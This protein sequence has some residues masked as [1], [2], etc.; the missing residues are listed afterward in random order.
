MAFID[1]NN[2]PAIQALAKDEFALPT[3]VG[4]PNLLLADT[5]R[6]RSSLTGMQT[7]MR[8]VGLGQI[9]ALIDVT[10]N[11][12]LPQQMRDLEQR[13]LD[14][15]RAYLRN[16]NLALL[17]EIFHMVQLWGGRAG[18]NIYVMKGKF[19]KN[20]KAKAYEEFVAVSVTPS[21][22]PGPDPRVPRLIAAADQ[23]NQF[24]V[25]FATKHARFW[26]QAANVQ[27][28]P[29]FDRIMALGSLGIKPHWN[30]YDRYI[31]GMATHAQQ[32]NTNVA[33]LERDAFAQFDTP[34]GKKWLDARKK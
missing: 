27:P 28:L 11:R 7:I 20:W 25:A 1:I 30:K 12:G 9:A 31:A 23:I 15:M 21:V 4:N 32:A 19:A 14:N 10:N 26:A 5:P 17:V 6:L 33:T 2:L 3:I 16:P 8:N 13:I 22:S 24:D 18:R 34:A 29:I